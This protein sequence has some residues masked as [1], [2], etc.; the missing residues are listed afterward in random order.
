MMNGG[1]PRR[2]RA[3]LASAPPGVIAPADRLIAAQ[4]ATETRNLR[5]VIVDPPINAS[6]TLFQ[7]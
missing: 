1:P 2:C 6:P 3:P 5:L 7:V 4:I